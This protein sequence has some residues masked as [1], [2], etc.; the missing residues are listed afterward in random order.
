MFI[1]APSG[2]GKTHLAEAVSSSLGLE[3]LP[4]SLSEWA[5]IG[6]SQRGA[7]CTWPAI[8]QFLIRSPKKDGYLIFLDELDKIGR[9]NQ[10]DWSRYQTTEVFSLLDRR[11]PRNLTDSDGDRISDARILDAETIL[12]TKTLIVAGGA[13]QAIWDAP[14]SIGFGAELNPSNKVPDLKRL[15]EF[16]PPELSPM[17]LSIR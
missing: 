9:L 11:V 17:P 14:N 4:I 7:S 15:S 1:V 13:F 6:S 5:V 2:S 3:Y 8:C 12:K 10:G 16:N